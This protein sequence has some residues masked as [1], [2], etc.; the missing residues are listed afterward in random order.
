MKYITDLGITKADRPIRVVQFGEGNFLRAFVD[1]MIDICNEKTDFNGSI[2]IVKP[3]S[4]G[5]L[6]RFAKQDCLYT[7][8]LRGQEKGE[9]VNTRRIVTSVNRAVDGADTWNNLAELAKCPTVRFVVSNTTEAGIVLD[10]SD[11]MEGVP[12]TYP[13]K[14]TKFLYERYLAFDGA[15]E[16]GVILL[17][18]ELIENNGGKLKE[19]VLRLAQVWNLPAGFAVWL[20]EHCTFCSTLVDRIVT[21][22][23]AAEAE[24]LWEELGYRDELLDVG[25]PFGLWVIESDRDV[26]REL[27]FAEAGLPVVFT[28]NQKPYRERKVRI[29]N[30]AHTSSVLAG[31]LYGKNIVRDMMKDP[32]TGTF[33]RQAVLDEIA[34]LVPLDRADV[35][36][37]AAAVFER[38]ENP[39]ID[40]ELLAI[41]LNSV[42]KWKARVLPSVRDHYAKYGTLPKKLTFSFAALLAFYTS[43]D[44]QED[45]LHAVRG[46]GTEYIIRDDRAV[47]EFFAANSSLPT[48]EFVDAVCANADFWGEDLRRYEGFTAVVVEYLNAIR[49]DIETA[50]R[51]MIN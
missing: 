32:V 24:A 16:K 49:C 12:A 35:D 22:Y 10:E 28:D 30:G 47:L 1:W 36:A 7:V 27:P 42:S 13:G 21:G 14:L 43:D 41:S 38:F 18:V 40:H 15:A 20:N 46:D 50:I 45:G 33:V 51:E 26:S 17:P 31:W 5:S 34:P 39:F 37:F 25:E 44:L 23:P 6:E 11:T 8:I 2:A 4:Y 29:L 3:I 19:C 48:T 9:V